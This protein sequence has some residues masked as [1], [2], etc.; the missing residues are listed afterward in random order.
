MTVNG[1]RVSVRE[2]RRK[3]ETDLISVAHRVV[4]CD[5]GC[6][7]GFHVCGLTERKEVM[8]IQRDGL[9]ESGLKDLLFGGDQLRSSYRLVAGAQ[10]DLCAVCTAEVE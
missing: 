8:T 2:R 7:K 9:T 6:L 1:C 10:T 5:A 4:V 3:S